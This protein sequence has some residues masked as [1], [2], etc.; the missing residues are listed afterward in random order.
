MPNWVTNKLTINGENKKDFILSLM[1]KDNEEEYFDFEKII[2]MPKELRIDKSSYN[3]VAM[4]L[5]LAKINPL[6]LNFGND[7]MYV[8][9][10]KQLIH[11]L[12]KNDTK[13]EMYY[14]INSNELEKILLMYEEK[15]KD[16]F[17][18]EIVK[19]IEIGEKLIN[20]VKKYNYPT[21]YEWSYANWG[22]KWNSNNTY[23][24][25]DDG[26]IYFDT[27]WCPSVEVIKELAKQH[28][29]YNFIHEYAEE[30]IAFYT[31]KLEYE[32]G[33]CIDNIEY[34]AYSKEAYELYFE[35]WGCEEDFK[36]DESKG[37]YIEKNEEEME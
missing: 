19:L 6:I 4:K 1:T 36:Y 22:V 32:N 20:N 17:D 34:E 24:N 28:P 27:A 21:W 26:I 11:L 10:F 15:F 29:D 16:K 31:G 14:V 8:N 13:K 37:T 9:E 25:L 18:D 12:F 2:P 35:L 30:Q 3:D 5:Y 33:E 7:K 23:Y